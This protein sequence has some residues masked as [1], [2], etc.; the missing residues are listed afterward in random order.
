[1]YF[2]ATANSNAFR[3]LNPVR[4][5]KHMTRRAHRFL[6]KVWRI[7]EVHFGEGRENKKQRLARVATSF[8]FNFFNQSSPLLPTITFANQLDML[9]EGIQAVVGVF[10]DGA[11]AGMDSLPMNV[12]TASQPLF[13]GQAGMLPA[14]PNTFASLFSLL[15]SFGALR[16]WVKIFLI[17][18]LLESCRRS[19]YT[20]YNACVEWFMLTVEISGDDPA[21]AWLLLWLSKHERWTKARTLELSSSLR[22]GRGRNYDQPEMPEGQSLMMNPSIGKYSLSRSKFGFSLLS[23][24][25]RLVRRVV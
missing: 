11:G 23:V 17:G 13:Q 18:G 5:A 25:S 24:E 7:T 9:V 12:T 8:P 14:T 15:L 6:G 4:L 19:A 1:M 21:Y 22:T 20:L 2:Q 16:D 3:D 10:T